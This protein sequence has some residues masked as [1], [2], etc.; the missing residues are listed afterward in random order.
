[1]EVDPNPFM[2]LSL[3][4]PVARG[5]GHLGNESVHDCLAWARDEAPCAVCYV[6]HMRVVATEIWHVLRDD[7]TFW[8]NIGDSY[9]GGGQ[10][11]SEMA[12]GVGIG[13]RRRVPD[14]LKP[15]DL[16]G[17]PWRVALALQADGWTLRS[18]V[19][20]SK[21]NGLP[22]SVTDRP[23]RAHEYV[24]LFVKSSHYYYDA[25]AVRGEVVNH[26]TR[27]TAENGKDNGEL[28]VGAR[29]GTPTTSKNLRSVWSIVSQPQKFTSQIVRQVRVEQGVDVGGTKRTTSPDCP[30]HGDRAAR[31]ATHADG[32]RAV[33]S[34]TH[35]ERI[36]TDREPTRQRGCAP[37]GPNCDDYFLDES[38]A[39]R[40]HVVRGSATVHNK[41][42]HKT[43]RDLATSP[44]CTTSEGTYGRTP[45][46]T[47]SRGSFA[48]GRGKIES[49]TSEGVEVGAKVPSLLGRKPFGNF[50]TPTACTCVYHKE[51]TEQIAH[52]AAFPEALVT[53]CVLAGTSAVGGCAT[54][55]APYARQLETARPR[56]AKPKHADEPSN[57]NTGL[58]AHRGY[59][60]TPTTTTTGWVPTCAHPVAPTVPNIV[61]DPFF[62]SGTVGAVAER[63]GR[64]W[65]G[66]DANPSYAPLWRE[67][68]GRR[69]LWKR[70]P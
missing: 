56:G 63:L 36:D 69:N 65:I 27:R 35:N 5:L 45:D 60:G 59:R 8:L 58:G 51:A 6:C 19:I 38:S 46:N 31:G 20:W 39:T 23:T 66:F 4:A 37:I 1:M 70:A 55:G 67:R 13:M 29:F 34:A 68:T 22:E 64:D 21:P 15:K 52:F 62:G 57:A 26:N 24:F 61:L 49:R 54:C 42:I 2:L 50:D 44:S 18:D 12:V 11:E 53:R 43:G 17:I 30:V 10:G 3:L 9:C 48:R 40:S 28:A 14:T 41:Q 16:V 7:G 25:D 33:G 32:E 47:E